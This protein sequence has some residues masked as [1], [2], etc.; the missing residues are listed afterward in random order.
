MT[1][2]ISGQANK[3]GTGMAEEKEWKK[4]E[5]EG[6]PKG[7][8]GM[9]IPESVRPEEAEGRGWRTRLIQC[10]NCGAPGLILSDSEWYTCWKCGV[11]ISSL[12]P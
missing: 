3:K 12:D 2:D 9:S 6:E 7:K 10:F 4:W 8:G 11:T 1:A 5:G